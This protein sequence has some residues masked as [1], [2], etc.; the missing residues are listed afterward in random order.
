MNWDSI[1]ISE[2][3]HKQKKIAGL[4]LGFFG[5]PAILNYGNP[6]ITHEDPWLCPPNHTPNDVELRAVHPSWCTIE[7]RAPHLFA[8]Q[9]SPD[10][11]GF[12]F[13]VF[14]SRIVNAGSERN[15][16]SQV[17]RINNRF[18]K[19]KNNSANTL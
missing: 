7:F 6:A 16:T 10:Y 19:A 2:S 11:S 9:G 8:M 4:P 15:S 17:Y 12:A 18:D 1:K 14:H 13:L 3:F 5:N